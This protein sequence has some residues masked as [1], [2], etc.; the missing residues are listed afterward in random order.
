MEKTYIENLRFAAGACAGRGVDLL[1]EPIND[2]DVPGYFLNYSEQARRIIEEVKSDNLFLQYDIYHMQI[3]EGDLATTI[4]KN[5]GIIRH[6]QLA[7]VPGR[8]EPDIGEINYPFLFDLIDEKQYEGW[9]GCEYRPRAGTEEGL[10]WARP[11]GIG[12]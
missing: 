3:M 9:I 2:H 1:I 4:D 7:G 10:G 6:F 11:Y 12:A 8:H 5:L